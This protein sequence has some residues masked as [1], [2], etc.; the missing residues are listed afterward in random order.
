MH[1]EPLV[2]QDVGMHA[3]NNASAGGLLVEASS[4]KLG[5]SRLRPESTTETDIVGNLKFNGRVSLVETLD[6][7][8]TEFIV[9][10][11]RSMVAE[12]TEVNELC[13]YLEDGLLLGRSVFTEPVTLYANESVRFIC[14]LH[15]NRC[16]LT[17]INV[18]V[19]DVH[20]LPSTPHVHK[21]PNPASSEVNAVL[22]LNGVRNV[23]GSDSPVVAMRQ[24]A[25]SSQWAFTDHTRVFQGKPSA[26]NA[27]GVTIAG[28]AFEL[29]EIAILHIV[30][31]GGVGTSRRVKF[32]GTR[33][34]ELDGESIVFD[35]NTHVALWRNERSVTFADLNCFPPT[36]GIP[37]DWVLTRG[38]E[39]EPIWAP[40]RDVRPVS[41]LLWRAPSKLRID[42]LN[43]TGDGSSARYA[44]A[45]SELESVNYLQPVVGGVSQHKTAFD[46]SGNEVE[47]AENLPASTPL[48]LRMYS[49]EPSTGTRLN[50]AIDQFT[51]D[52]TTQK[53][54]LSQPV[55]SASYIKV[56]VR[57]VYQNATTF[58]Y[59]TSDN[60]VSLVAPVPSGMAV[61]IRSYR[62]MQSE[63]YSTDILSFVTTVRDTAHF[64][65]LPF[66]PQ[67]AEYLEIK[68]SGSH[69][70]FSQYAVIDNKVILKGPIRRG[71]EV[72]V[73]LYNNIRTLGSNS[74]DLPGVVVDA[75][76]TGHSLQLIRHNAR[77]VKLPI[78]AVSLH[79]GPG[80]KISGTHPQYRIE[81]TI[82]EQQRDSKANF[83]ISDYRTLKDATEIMFTHR[84]EVTRDMFI[85]VTADFSAIL[86][87]GFHSIQESEHVEF[88]V[89]FRT[90]S[91]TEA[92]YGRGL[93]GTGFAGFSTLGSTVYSNA[94]STQVYEVIAANHKSGY[95]DVV[96][97]MRV[98]NANVGNYGSKLSINTNITGNAKVS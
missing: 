94:S 83:K 93:P 74:S 95:I 79:S 98:K 91:S 12:D 77:P 48:E 32:T 49:R 6:K 90:S 64:I 7:N 20:S 53:F 15:T 68:V 81:S 10:V 50:I 34:E 5:D 69:L 72:E 29:N 16:D 45:S 23:D 85:S 78:P 75:V 62:N 92:D 4:F 33:F 18:S 97:K 38:P 9:E 57:G 89:G 61:E 43:Y 36:E 82:A 11:H 42:I 63:G 60:S 22:V 25:G 47:F 54:T 70:H 56:F 2:L 58:V 40:P 55:D 3:I 66:V 88:V 13:L 51:G 96:T 52:G 19:N 17:T 21:L 8:T 26:I 73:T 31:G 59:D 14:L 39:G 80:I 28:Q 65:E 41:N 35:N 24:R 84:V 86:G 76:L 46:I 71:L 30:S 1:T 37:K 67:S 27:T 87:P 44:L